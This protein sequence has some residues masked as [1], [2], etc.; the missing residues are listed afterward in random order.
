[1]NRLEQSLKDLLVHTLNDLFVNVN[2]IDF[3]K[4][5]NSVKYLPTF[6]PD[7]MFD[8]QKKIVHTNTKQIIRDCDIKST[9]YYQKVFF[10]LQQI[11]T[12]N[13]RMRNQQSIEEITRT[14]LRDFLISYFDDVGFIE[15]NKTKFLHQFQ[16]FYRY[17]TE[18]MNT[19]Y[20]FATLTNFNG[21]FDEQELHNGLHIRKITADE[22]ATISGIEN[23]NE[24]ID[25]D[26]SL[27]KIKYIIGK[28]LNNTRVTESIVLKLFE[29]TLDALKIFR[30]GDV[31]LGGLYFRD[32]KFWNVKTT[33]IL[34]REPRTQ[35][36]RE[37]FMSKH[38]LLDD[39]KTF[40]K[41]FH[42]INLTKRKYTILG[43]SIR[44]FSKAI[45]GDSNDESIVDFVTNLESLFSS[46][47]HELSYKFSLRIA[48]LLG[49]NTEEMI[50]LQNLMQE[51]YNMRSKIVHGD[52]VP[53][54][55]KLKNKSL[56]TTQAVSI[57]EQVS[58]NSIMIFLEL[59]EKYE[60]KDIIHQ[61]IEAAIFDNNIR[62][63][64]YTAITSSKYVNLKF[65]EEL[66]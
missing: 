36:T 39:F 5:Y 14:E 53:Q 55:I 6:K 15:F 62:S 4:K 54:Q 26:S 30:H 50:G 31:Q 28:T 13:I 1:M 12:E 35:P 46:N 60:S 19:R 52:N 16:V 22:F 43:R 38:E 23:H 37:Y 40:H 3:E 20:C 61:N 29:K 10:E 32:S 24:K 59:L 34:R 64:F 9:P 8:D 27:F 44:R 51:I 42:D 2:T 21:D 66:V 56:E 48:V 7:G 33:L 58:R 41:K 18:E 47:E 11:I 65:L 17:L 49:R 45:E 25:V 57:L 63:E